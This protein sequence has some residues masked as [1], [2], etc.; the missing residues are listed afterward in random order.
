MGFTAYTSNSVWLNCRVE[1]ENFVVLFTAEFREE[2]EEIVR[3]VE[4]GDEITFRG[5]FY[6]EGCEFTDCELIE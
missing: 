4:K 1:N 6:D 3:S 5:R 2:F